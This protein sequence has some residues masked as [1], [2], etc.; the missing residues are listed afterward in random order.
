MT[1]AV[2]ERLPQITFRVLT[3]EGPTPRTTDDIFKGRRVVLVG[4]PGA[5]TPTCHRNHAPG[6]I[7]NLDAFKE[8]GIDA[9]LI[10]STNDAFVLDA[11]AKA[12]G[13]DG[14]IEFLSDGNADFARA[15]G[16][17]FDG[18]GFGLGPRSQRYAMVVNDG[19]VEVL[20]VEE[21]AGQ[22][23]VTSAEH[24]LESL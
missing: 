14:Q 15:T 16:L 5:F 12:L 22:V 1:I 9:V 2:G 23:Q 7:A 10:T 11:W 8:K 13:A 3:S 24:L 17:L 6:F 4:V 19:V 20:N 21:A 18:S